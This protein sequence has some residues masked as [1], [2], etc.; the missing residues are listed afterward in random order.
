MT[1]SY[2]EIHREIIELS[3]AGNRKA[4]YQLYT[5]YVRSMFN[6][7]MRMLN[8]RSDA[9]D[10]LQDS[11]SEIFYRLETYRFESSFGAWARR[12]VIN[13]CLNRL[14]K[15]KVPLVFRD[16]I[17]ESDAEEET[18]DGNTELKLSAVRHALELLPEGYRIIFSLYM[19]EGYDHGEIADILGIS[20]STSKTQY[21]KAK[22]KLKQLIHRS[23]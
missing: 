7:C 8:N 21:M 16:K 11:F 2:R 3:I 9:E 15:R 12:I 5:L 20:V 22:R 10:A 6:I 13:T 23:S 19:I 4:Q 14:K 18:E 1:T 17:D